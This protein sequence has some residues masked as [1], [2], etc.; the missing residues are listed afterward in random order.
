[1]RASADKEPDEALLLGRGVLQGAP[2]DKEPDEAPEEVRH[3][4]QRHHDPNRHRQAQVDAR[5]EEI[6]QRIET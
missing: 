1:M 5:C 3:H 4:V 2:V 6:C